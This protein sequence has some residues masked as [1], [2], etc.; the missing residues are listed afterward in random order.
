MS[1]EEFESRMKK[2]QLRNETKELKE[3]LKAE[4]NKYR[5]KIGQ[6]SNNETSKL[7]AVYLFIVFNVILIY[8]LV[9]MW[10]FEDLSYLGVLIT[11]IAAQVLLFGIYCLKAYNGKKQE[12]MMKFEKEKLFGVITSDDAYTDDEEVVG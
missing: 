10:A 12:E 4:K 5:R 8:S 6:K 3:K 11:D 7:I 2:I 9:A 1:K